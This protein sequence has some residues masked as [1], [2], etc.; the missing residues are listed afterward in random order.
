[1]NSLVN[2]KGHKN[3]IRTTLD[4]W[5]VPVPYSKFYSKSQ[6]D[7][8]PLS[9]TRRS[10]AVKVLGFFAMCISH[11]SITL[12]E[13]LLRDSK[14]QTLWTSE[15]Q[16]GLKPL[17]CSWTLCGHQDVYFRPTSLCVNLLRLDVCAFSI[18]QST[19]QACNPG[20]QGSKSAPQFKDLFIM[21][22]L[23]FY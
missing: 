6:G 3:F 20:Q 4:C 21:Y 5:T 16:P 11:S 17:N 8:L 12:R 18:T 10:T 15:S 23:W 2:S 7:A 9:S 22:N 1:M 14:L 13:S 19:G